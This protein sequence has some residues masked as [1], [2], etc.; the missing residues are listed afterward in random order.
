MV[1]VERGNVVLRVDEADIQY[2]LNQG[3]NLTDET[4]T[5]L[6]R[7]IP[8]NLGELQTYY[9]KSTEKI[10]ELEDTIAKLTA[11]LDSKKTATRR[12]K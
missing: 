10:A 6:Q 9:V 7:A 1:R 2:Y 4:G 5:I 3:Y 11:Q 8:T 12:S